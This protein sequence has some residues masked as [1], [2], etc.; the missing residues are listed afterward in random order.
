MKDIELLDV[1][2]DILSKPIEFL[3]KPN[4]QMVLGIIGDEMQMAS[5]AMYALRYDRTIDRA[6]GQ[7]LDDIGEI[8]G[9]PRAVTVN[10][11]DGVFTFYGNAYGD[12]FDI[13]KFTDPADIAV[14]LGSRDDLVY[15]MDIRARII[16]NNEAATPEDIIKMAK[17]LLGASKVRFEANDLYIRLFTDSNTD[18]LILAYAHQF[19]QKAL[20]AGVNLEFIS[21]VLIWD[22]TNFDSSKWDTFGTSLYDQDFWDQDY[23]N[24]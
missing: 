7:L 20:P 22:E 6:Y 19:I 10:V 21:S 1:K 12:G 2:T 3:N 15:R 5:L 11:Y 17:L 13:G 16:A 4:M 18:T 23:W 24:K 9:E 8:V 14:D